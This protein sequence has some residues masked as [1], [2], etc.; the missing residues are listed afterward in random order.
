MTRDRGREFVVGIVFFL[1][2][3]GLGGITILLGKDVLAATAEVSFRFSD[4]AGLDRGAEVWVNGLP[5]GTVREVALA[6]DGTVTATVR[7]K[8]DL[9][10]L[11]LSKGV[12]VEVKEKSSLGGA[13]VSVTTLRKPDPSAPTTLEA[14][15]GRTWGARAGG[16]AS[17]GEG[18][19]DRL[20]ASS[21]EKPGFLGKAI[22]GEKGFAD[23]EASLGDLKLAIG[24]LR[25]LTEGADGKDSVLNVLLRDEGTAAK[26]KSTIA[27]LEEITGKA[28]G[29]DGLIG[30]LLSDPETTRKFDRILDGLDSFS[31]DLRNR[32][33][34]IGKLLNDPA[35]YDDAKAALADIR[36][37]TSG[38]NDEKGLLH[39]LMHDGKM[40]DD[41]AA[42]VADARL[43]LEDLRGITA[44][45]R[46]GKGTLGKL[47]TDDSLHAD[48]K[49]TLAT[50]QRSFEEARENAPILTFAGFL[51]RTF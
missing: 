19:V 48:L 30:K 39:R 28:K 5:S 43:T 35:L 40:A 37:F 25:K 12:L 38:M 31:A 50:L 4:A 33:G 14:L 47:V 23:L 17:V 1:L 16:F 49:Y 18:A 21:E 11:D 9:G 42:A 51:F 34:T 6:P 29:G 41:L 8:H 20:V 32:E 3:A 22:L 2:L 15:Q 27:N 13:V 24:D 44:D 7:M 10:A 45:I 36:K 26:L 46:A